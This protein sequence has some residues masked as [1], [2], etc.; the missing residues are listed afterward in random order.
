[1]GLR[2][3]MFV[4]IYVGMLRWMSCSFTQ[5]LLYL[6]ALKRYAR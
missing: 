3:A 6:Q 5:F 2:D 4:A 1:M